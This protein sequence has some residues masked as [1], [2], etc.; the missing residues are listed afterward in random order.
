LVVEAPLTPVC[1]DTSLGN[2]LAEEV[3]CIHPSFA[4]P[5][6]PFSHIHREVKWGESRFDFLLSP[7][8]DREEAIKEARKGKFVE[9]KSVSMADSSIALFPD[10]PTARGQK[11]MRELQ[12]LVEEGYSAAVLFLVMRSDCTSFAANEIIDPKYAQSLALAQQ[13]GVEV[14]VH[15]AHVEEASLRPGKVL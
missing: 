1:I 12:S 9:V 15:T 11:H 6:G 2:V 14:V 4:Q 13:A 7:F 5:A 3:L 10:S 8:S